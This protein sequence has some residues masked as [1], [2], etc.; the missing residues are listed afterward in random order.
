MGTVIELFYNHAVDVAADI[1]S[2]GGE[3]VDEVIA[4]L[5]PAAIAALHELED[6]LYVAEGRYEAMAGGQ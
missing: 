5:E 1:Y 3:L 2:D 6:R 4:H